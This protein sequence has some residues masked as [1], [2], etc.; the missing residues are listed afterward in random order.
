MK[1]GLGVLAAVGMATAMIAAEKT[2]LNQRQARPSPAWLTGGVLYQIQPRAF[3]PEG[4]LKAAQARLPRLAELGVTVLYLCPVFVADDDMDRAFWSPRQKKSGMNNPRNPYRMKDFYHVDPEYGTDQDL[5]DFVAAAHALSLRV[6]LDMVYLHC[7]PK[8]VFIEPNPDFV[9]RAEDGKVK[10]AGWSFPGLNFKSPGLREYL[11]KNMEMWIREFNVDGFRCDVA[12][13][14]PLDFWEEGRA[15]IE[16]IKPDVGMLAEGTRKEDQLKAFDLD[17]GW[18]AVFKKWDN[19]GA[20]RKQWTAMRDQRPR[21]GAKFVRFIDNHDIAND[22]YNNRL[23]KRWGAARVEAALVWLFTMDGV[24]FLYN[25]QE[26]A[27]AARHSIFGRAPIDW[28]NGGTEAG[29][30]RFAFVQSL[31]ALRKSEPALT[32]GDLVWLDTDQPETV[33]AFAR[34]LQGTRIVSVINLSGQPVKVTVKGAEGGLTPLLTR[35][36]KG[37]G[38]TECAIGPHG[39][40]VGKAGPF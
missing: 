15:R 16:R 10:N 2:P 24:P 9:K 39:F 40:F 8:A 28:A 14:I 29:K 35:D 22:D 20:I 27:D 31:C 12:D 21:G 36:A 33:S 37:V 30:A 4:T 11:W 17:Y 13:G 6:M 3:T 1:R 19:A 23:E 32:R 5:K 25:G 7:G 38:Q 34:T 26:V 18:G